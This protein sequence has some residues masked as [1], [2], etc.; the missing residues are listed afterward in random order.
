MLF[1]RG[2]CVEEEMEG[3]ANSSTRNESGTATTM[4]A[5]ISKYSTWFGQ[6]RNVSNPWMARYVYG[7]IFLVA[8]LLGWAARDYARGA[9]TEMESKIY[10][11]II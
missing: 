1:S 6:F 4:M 10:H 11:H 3:G 7:F 9:L 5:N 8:N 2:G